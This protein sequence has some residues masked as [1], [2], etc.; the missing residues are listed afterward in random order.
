MTDSGFCLLVNL[1]P[2]VLELLQEARC[3]TKLGVTVPKVVLK[4][5]SREA[6]IKALYSR[7]LDLLQ[8]YSSAVSRV[9]PLLL[10]VM[11]PF[12]SRVEAALS[13]GLTTLSWASLNTDAFIQGVYGALKELDQVAKVASDLLE[14]RIGRL[15]ESMSSCCLLVLPEDSPVSPQDLLLQ[16]D[17]SV[18]AAAATLGWQSQQLQKYVSQLVEELKRRMKAAEMLNLE[19][20]PTER[21]RGLSF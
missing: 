2:V 14:C 3:M 4:M 15:L 21:R 8:D 12:V 17:R 13:P 20:T 16:A 5:T 18:R 7:L 19:V 6:Q 1:D 10:P 11:Q 9:P